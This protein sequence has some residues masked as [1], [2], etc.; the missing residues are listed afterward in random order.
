MARNLA[1]LSRNSAFILFPSPLLLVGVPD[2]S[3]V[4]STLDVEVQ[5]GMHAVTKPIH[6]GLPATGRHV[7]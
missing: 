1:S 5:V 2:S 7:S 3:V 4:V 6:L